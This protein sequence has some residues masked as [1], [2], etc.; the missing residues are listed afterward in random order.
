MAKFGKILL[1]RIGGRDPQRGEIFDKLMKVL[2][3]PLTGLKPVRTGYNAFTEREEDIDK[4]LT[5][6]AR[7]VLFDIGLEVKVP[8]QTKGP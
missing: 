6:E 4:L 2:K 3:T 8:P 7:K 1:R 5:N